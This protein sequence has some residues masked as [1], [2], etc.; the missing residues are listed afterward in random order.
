MVSSTVTDRCPPATEASQE[1][2]TRVRVRRGAGGRAWVDTRSGLLVPRIVPGDPPSG[3]T[4]CS[5][6]VVLVAAGALL[7]AGDDLALEVEVEAG[8]RL[9]LTE[10]AATV[11]YDGR[12]ERAS[13]RARLR[14]AAGAE[15]V[16]DGAPFVV[17]DGADVDRAL[18]ADVAAGGRLTLRDT[19]V[20]GRYGER[21]GALRSRTRLSYGGAP[22]LAEDLDLAER[23]AEPDDLGPSAG[24]RANPGDLPGILRGVRVIDQRVT[25]GPAVD[26]V[27]PP[28]AAATG[29][30]STPLLVPG[31][32]GHL[33][34]WLGAQAHESGLNC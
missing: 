33:T 24:A 4:T 11:A 16:W 10:V 18:H 32:Q 26:P 1:S 5:A 21:G 23:P 19:L 20:L 13:W 8:V 31:G 27:A 25:L 6:H 34:R 2:V 3:D 30:L 14:V 22:V 9:R 28:S 17:S 15:L 7:L 12:G 29:A